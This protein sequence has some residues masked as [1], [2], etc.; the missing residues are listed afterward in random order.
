LDSKKTTEGKEPKR[1]KQA[2]GSHWFTQES[3]RNTKLEAINTYSKD[4]LQTPCLL[5]LSL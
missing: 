4:L 5:L 2:L 1:K 3:Q